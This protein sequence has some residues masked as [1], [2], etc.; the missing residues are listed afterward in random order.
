MGSPK[1]LFLSTQLPFPPKSGGTMKSWNYVNFLASKYNV[2]VACLLKDDDSNYVSLFKEA[3]KI[4]HFVG[5][6]VSVGRSPINLIKSYFSAPSL[7]VLRNFSKSFKSSISSIIDSFDII[8]VDHYE[9]FQYVPQNFNGKVVMHTH[10]AEFMLWQRMSELTNNPIKKILLKIEAIRVKKYENKIFNSSDLIYSTPSDIELYQANE[11]DISRH[12]E[13]FHL[14]NDDLLTLPNLEFNETEKAIT[15]IGTLSWEPNIDG[16]VWFL[17]E[18]WPIILTQHP[19]CKLYVLGK[20]PDKRII[21]SAN[22]ST[23]IVFTGF[24]KEL[25][26]YLNKTRVY[27]A[28]L[29]FGSGMKV[30]VLE[31]LY[32]GVPSVSTS[33]GTEGLKI[34]HEEHIMIANDSEAFAQH[35]LSLIKDVPLWERLRDNSRIIARENYRWVPLF[36]QMDTV[37]VENFKEEFE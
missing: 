35:C 32:R 20:N 8:I 34:A 18:V 29:R 27:I 5:E 6:K 26:S 13:T 16:L 11:F 33:V 25:E 31:G 36:K 28:P 1:I 24:V 22:N 9:V 7:N 3:I 12:A 19:D 4:E 30:K 15:F 23:S 21:A 17:E 14:G 37:L 2:S 10:N